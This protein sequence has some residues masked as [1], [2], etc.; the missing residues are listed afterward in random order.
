MTV[1]VTIS[2]LSAGFLEST[3]SRWQW[4]H[5]T[6]CPSRKRWMTWITSWSSWSFLATFWRPFP[7]AATRTMATTRELR[8]EHGDA[9]A[10]IHYLISAPSLRGI[11][12]QLD[13]LF[14][15]TTDATSKLCTAGPLSSPTR[16]ACNAEG[17]QVTKGQ[18]KC[19]AEVWCFLC[20]YPEQSVEQMIELSVV[21]STT[22]PM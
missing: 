8:F 14:E 16:K 3:Q 19:D 6:S 20:C 21:W 2:I 1:A 9:M 13:C 22:A 18:Y 5:M 15:L 4:K 11:H 7:W 17:V 12:W 10:C